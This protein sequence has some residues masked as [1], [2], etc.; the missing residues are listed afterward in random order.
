MIVALE[1]KRLELQEALDLSKTPLERNKLGQFATPNALAS[2][3]LAYAKSL[4]PHT[5]GIRFL[6]PAFGTGAFYSALLARFP[7]S[8]LKGTVGYEI[9]PHYGRRAVELWKDTPLKLELEDFTK[10]LPPVDESNKPNLVICNPPYVRHHH[11]PGDEKPRLKTLGFKSA[12]VELSG[13]S[14]LYCYF[15]CLSQ[16]WMARDA[17][18]IWLIPSEFMDVNYGQAVKEYLLNRVTLLRIH[19]FD[20]KDVQFDDALVSSAV[21]CFKNSPPPPCHTVDFTYGGS[22]T[23]SHRTISLTADSLRRPKKW[24]GLVF[25]PSPSSPNSETKLSDFFTIKRGIATGSNSFFVLSKDKAALLRIPRQ[26]LKPILPSPRNMPAD[27]VEA[28]DDGNPLVD[29]QSFLL[30]CDLPEDE[31]R[32]KHPALWRY[33]EHGVANGIDRGYIC[34]HRSPW[35]SQEKRQAPAILCTYMGR[36]GKTTDAF[37]FILNHSNAIAANVY[38]MLYPKPSLARLI[39]K[40]PRLLDAIWAALRR[41]PIEALTGVGRVYGGGLHKLEPKELADAPVDDILEI[42]PRMDRKRKQLALF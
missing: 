11:L 17:L 14:G 34:A 7:A 3:I 32:T 13:L 26:F 15:L 24:T 33:I 28:D 35:Y 31:V 27:I 41:I 1:K 20:P 8:A 9:D 10:A 18:A 23:N 40:Q 36:K 42:L 39:Q 16:A 30:N 12:G 21:V 22:L 29:K 2:D 6:D 37:R 38:L 5:T 19:R 25:E 4:L